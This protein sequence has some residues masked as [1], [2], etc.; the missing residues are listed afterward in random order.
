[1]LSLHD[2]KARSA[3]ESANNKRECSS[4]TIGRG[5]MHW[6][7]HVSIISR[8]LNAHCFIHN[9]NS[10]VHSIIWVESCCKLTHSC[11]DCSFVRLYLM[12]L[13]K[14]RKRQTCSTGCTVSVVFDDYLFWKTCYLLWCDVIATRMSGS[15]TN[16]HYLNSET[17]QTT[18]NTQCNTSTN[19]GTDSSWTNA[20][21]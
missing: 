4:I 19:S 1:M 12:T 7:S 11:K 17:S 14:D 16:D 18:C 15:T 9:Y 10:T 5:S 8:L 13:A 2:A 21:T 20:V 6:W 3:Y